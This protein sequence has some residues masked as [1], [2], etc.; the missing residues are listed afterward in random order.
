MTEWLVA[1]A[2]AAIMFLVLVLVVID[3]RTKQPPE[4]PKSPPVDKV[5]F[6]KALAAHDWRK[7][8]ELIQRKLKT[9]KDAK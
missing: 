7:A 8:N 9:P 3:R 1:I 6:E 5:A 2:L 4:Q